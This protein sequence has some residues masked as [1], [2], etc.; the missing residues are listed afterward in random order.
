MYCKENGLVY[1]LSGGSCLGAV[2]HQGFIPW[3]HDADIMMPRKDYEKFLLNF[4]KK[5]KGKY[6]VG[7]LLTEKKWIRQY[8]KVWDTRTRLRDKNRN[9]IERGVSVD[10]FPIDGL[11]ENEKKR[12]YYYKLSKLRYYL[13]LQFSRKG[14]ND[15]EK[16]KPIKAILRVIPGW[17]GSRFLSIQINKAAKKYDFDTSKYVGVSVACHY[18]DKETIERKDMDYAVYL[19]FEGKMFP[20]VN[21]YDQYL[22]NL[23]G[24]YMIFSKKHV[25]DQEQVISNWELIINK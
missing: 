17:R 15:N 5:Y 10:I 12:K 20:V 23:Y 18:W 7:S 9:D 19:L 14:F 24:D 8:S 2:R 1:Y 25:E 4:E 6:K 11:P 3:D 22:K 21:G 16:F 13:Q